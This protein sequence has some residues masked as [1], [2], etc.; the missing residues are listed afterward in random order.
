MIVVLLSA[1]ILCALMLE[2]IIRDGQERNFARPAENPLSTVM[3]DV[4]DI[5]ATNVFRYLI[6]NL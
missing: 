1:L 2:R 6:Q 3:K 5:A 4:E